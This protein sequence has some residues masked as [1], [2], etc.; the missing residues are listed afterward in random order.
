MHCK[1]FRS[2]FEKGYLLRNRS[3]SSMSTSLTISIFWRWLTPRPNEQAKLSACES[4]AQGSTDEGKTTNT[5]AA[6]AALKGF[7][8]MLLRPITHKVMHKE[9]D[10]SLFWR[11]DDTGLKSKSKKR[12][13]ELQNAHEF[14]THLQRDNLSF[15]SRVPQLPPV[16]LLL[17]CMDVVCLARRQ[18]LWP[19]RV[20]NYRNSA[21][22]F[23]A[24]KAFIC[25]PLLYLSGN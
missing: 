8:A 1:H 25:M 7:A 19:S 5:W 21:V 16:K 2:Y 23:H 18:Q 9:E 3:E 10:S 17:I 24:V 22:A 20:N 4:T 6:W 14:V 11:I 13:G 12:R 15:P